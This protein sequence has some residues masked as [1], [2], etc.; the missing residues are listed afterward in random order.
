MLHSANLTL[1]NGSESLVLLGFYKCLLLFSFKYNP[2]VVCRLHVV[3]VV[4]SHLNHRKLSGNYVAKSNCHDV[5]QSEV[6]PT[7][8]RSFF[9]PYMVLPRSN[10]SCLH[11]H[12]TDSNYRP[13]CLTLRHRLSRQT[14]ICPFFVEFAVY[15]YYGVWLVFFYCRID[16]ST[17][18]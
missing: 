3:H 2:N 11:S 16:F 13:H 8:R 7:S 10:Y 14:I 6:A 4:F 17:V 15:L 18:S 12:G 9:S 5:Y 1:K